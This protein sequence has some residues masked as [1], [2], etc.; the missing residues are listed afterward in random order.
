MTNL[1]KFDIFLSREGKRAGKK[2]PPQTKKE[3]VKMRFEENRILEW[4]KDKLDC[5]HKVSGMLYAEKSAV[6]SGVYF[7]INEHDILRED[8][9]MVEIGFLDLNKK[10]IV[11]IDY[12]SSRVEVELKTSKVTLSVIR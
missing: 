1:K 5:G 2:F 8:E 11:D 6:A 9:K 10:E 7:K 4:I 3:M 12:H